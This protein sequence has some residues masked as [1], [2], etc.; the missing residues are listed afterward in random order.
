RD[1][2]RDQLWLLLDRT[3]DLTKEHIGRGR[4]AQTEV[5]HSRGRVHGAQAFMQRAQIV[6]VWARGADAL[7]RAIAE[8]NVNARGGAVRRQGASTL[9]TTCGARRR[10]QGGKHRDARH[11]PDASSRVRRYQGAS[12]KV[13]GR[14]AGRVTPASR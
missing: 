5:D 12:G 9:R 1:R 6:A 7:D 14:I 13:S 3:A 2:E 10:E 8:G 11:Q 4:A